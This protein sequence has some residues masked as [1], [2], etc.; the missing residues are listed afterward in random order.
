MITDGARKWWALGALA[1]SM[2]AVGLDL[3][4]LNVALPTL[5]ADLHASTSQLQWFASGYTLVLAAALLPAGTLGDR[6]GRRRFLVIAL[7]VFGLASLGCA[8]APSAEVLIA[9]RAVLGL[10]AAFLMPLSMSV[11]PVLFTEQERPKAIAVWASATMIGIPLGPIVGGWLLD[12]FW[13]GS[14]FL[15]NVPMVLIA[16]VA[17][18]LLL[19]ESRSS[20]RAGLDVVGVLT[21]SLG[22]LGVTYG[23]IQAGSAGWGSADTLGPLVAGLALLAGFVGWQR[24]K[25]GGQPLVDLALFASPS[26]TW[27][28]LLATMVNFAMVGLLFAMPQY[29]QAIEHT[30]ALGNGLRLL[31]MIGGMLVGVRVATLIAARAGAKITVTIGYTIMAGALALGA[32]TGL[33]SAYG[34]VAIWFSLLGFGLGFAMPTAINA[35]MSPLS[36]ERSGIGSSVMS[37]LRQTGGAIGVAI[38]GTVL[39][40]GYQNGLH[41]GGLPGAAAD[42]VRGGVTAG[43]AVAGELHSAPLLAMVR[44]AFVHGLDL[45]LWVSGG[46][47]LLGAI[48]A[49]AL[50]PA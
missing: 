38:L 28:T 36:A 39:S 5:S 27:G 16:L 44:G 34:F 19:P 1:L 12:N 15:I 22:L 20:A 45:T 23:V 37:A 33:G 50:L 18:G 21:S 13:W 7:I 24:A 30:D 10:A 11:L 14:A 6:Y 29:F 42:A 17:V 25:E 2:L 46:L 49:C 26:F 48:V 43:V 9:A 31:P 4:V 32:T 40:S 47:A 41:L 3:T 8:Y 35:A